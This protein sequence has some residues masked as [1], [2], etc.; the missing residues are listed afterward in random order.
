MADLW[1]T[2]TYLWT[3]LLG[4]E[5]FLSQKP[6]AML[7]ARIGFACGYG[8]VV[9]SFSCSTWLSCDSRYCGGQ[10]H[11]WVQK[12]MEPGSLN[13]CSAWRFRSS[14]RLQHFQTWLLKLRQNSCMKNL[15][16]ALRSHTLLT[17]SVSS[18]VTLLGSYC[19]R[20]LQLTIVAWYKHFVLKLGWTYPNTYSV[21]ID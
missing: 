7:V 8:G 17:C 16:R 19:P 1:F 3:C 4:I 15:S 13:G 18:W 12:W 11:M 2:K 9:E 20:R 6:A 5:P 21:V 14:L 10:K